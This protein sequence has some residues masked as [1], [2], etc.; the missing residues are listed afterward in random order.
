MYTAYDFTSR[1][2]IQPVFNLICMNT[3]SVSRSCLRIRPLFHI[4]FMN[5]VRPLFHIMFKNRASVSRSCLRIR[6]LFRIMFKNTA[7][8]FTSCLWIRPL[9][10]IMFINIKYGLCFTSCLWIR[11]LFHIM[12]KNTASF[13][14]AGLLFAFLIM[15]KLAFLPDTTASMLCKYLGVRIE[16]KSIYLFINT[17]KICICLAALQ[18]SI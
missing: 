4:M 10:R 18:K 6:P 5:T 2:W 14:Q 13:S 1:L 17:P 8:D 15:S 11:P 7:S 12:F 16:S 3:A 9:F